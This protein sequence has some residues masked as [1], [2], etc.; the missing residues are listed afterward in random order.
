MRFLLKIHMPV[1]AGNRALRDGSLPRIVQNLTEKLKPEASYFFAD[2]GK[3]TAYI[4]FSFDNASEIPVIAE[5]LF[6]GLNAELE[7]IPVMNADE[8]K[9]GLEKASKNF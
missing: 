8:L 7:L 5:P 3:R 4:F 1:K 9:A 2:N 6:M